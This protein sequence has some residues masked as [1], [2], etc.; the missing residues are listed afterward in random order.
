MGVFKKKVRKPDE[1]P[2]ELAAD[3]AAD[4]AGE[5]KAEAEVVAGQA[6][7][8]EKTVVIK[9]KVEFQINGI[10]YSPGTQYEVGETLA[11]GASQWLEVVTDAPAAP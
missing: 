10:R 7:A 5:A 1:T 9:P 2:D 11:A 4:A 3:D 6:E 8:G